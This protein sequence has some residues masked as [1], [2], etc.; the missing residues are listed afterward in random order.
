MRRISSVN[1]ASELPV[2]VAK[3]MIV[4]VIIM[5]RFPALSFL[6]SLTPLKNLRNSS[7]SCRF[8]EHNEAMDAQV[9]LPDRPGS[10]GRCSVRRKS[11]NGKMQL[12]QQ[13]IPAATI[14]VLRAYAYRI[15]NL[16]PNVIVDIYR[17]ILP[18]FQRRNYRIT[19]L[20]IQ[21]TC[22]RAASYVEQ[23]ISAVNEICSIPTFPS[24]MV[25]G[26][27]SDGVR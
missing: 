18:D 3:E 26:T 11:R 22:G 1:R 27:S 5:L 17:H 7:I 16:R 8:A 6:G 4:G 9:H 10:A 21:S 25:N 19:N 24:A 13:F 23:K 2:N 12:I 14:V 20:L 15:G